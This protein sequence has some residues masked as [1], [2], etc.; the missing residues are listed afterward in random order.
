MSIRPGVA[1]M[2]VS[3]RREGTGGGGQ[4]FGMRE[5]FN[6]L[7][8][9]TVLTIKVKNA[10][11]G[12]PDVGDL[13]LRAQVVDG[14]AVLEGTAPNERLKYLAQDLAEGVYGVEEADN[15]IRVSA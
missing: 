9:D 1:I 10:L 12:D 2:G 3:F 8:S 6:V 15:R 14:V 5:G 11:R 4:G 7:V 13:D